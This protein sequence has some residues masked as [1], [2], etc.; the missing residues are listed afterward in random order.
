MSN[1]YQAPMTDGKPHPLRDV[2]PA[3][4]RAAREAMQGAV[5]WKDVHPDMAEPI[6]DAIVMSLLPWL[7]IKAV[8]T[9]PTETVTIELE[10]WEARRLASALT[11][12]THQRGG[13]IH[14][15][16]FAMPEKI[17]MRKLLANL[18]GTV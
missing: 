16:E 12:L 3:V 9:L 8:R 1:T 14:R 6:A 17:V 13:P 2:D 4:L 5:V 7:C 11:R 10:P 15:S 18:N